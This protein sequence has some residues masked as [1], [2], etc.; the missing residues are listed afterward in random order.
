MRLQVQQIEVTGYGSD[1][2]DL[3]IEGF[4]TD[5]CLE[6]IDAQK[7]V[8]YYGENTLLDLIGKEEAMAYFGLVEAE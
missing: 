8:N 5:D 1:L 3:E 7:A 6:Q 2:I 4:D